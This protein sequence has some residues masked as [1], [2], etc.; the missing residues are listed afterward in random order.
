MPLDTIHQ[1]FW[2]S[3]ALRVAYGYLGPLLVES[4]GGLAI[5]HMIP[6]LQLQS[7]Y[8]WL[9]HSGGSRHVL[10]RLSDGPGNIAISA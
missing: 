10:L 6:P 4:V 8:L 5:R 3:T 1:K 9:F 7:R 2:G